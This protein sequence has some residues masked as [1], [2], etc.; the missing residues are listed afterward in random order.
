MCTMPAFLKAV[1]FHLGRKAESMRKLLLLGLAAMGL[2]IAPGPVAAQVVVPNSLASTDGN[3]NNTFPF[4]VTGGQ[5]YQQVYAANQFP[6]AMTIGQIAFR[7]D[8]ISNTFTRNLS[9][10]VI[11]LST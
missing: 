2:V 1:A 10:V 11:T 6:G 5:R 3:G 9:S 7:P 4:F 8:S